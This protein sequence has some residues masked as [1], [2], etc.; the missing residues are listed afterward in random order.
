MPNEDKSPWRLK[1]K[2]GIL[3]NIS[4]YSDGIKE[5]DN[6]QDAVSSSV[7]YRFD[8]I[9]SQTR[10]LIDITTLYLVRDYK[11][12]TLGIDLSKTVYKHNIMLS[13]TLPRFKK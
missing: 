2:E 10:L 7:K 3:A 5:S 8:S 12:T 6:M 13:C 4:G 1:P 11:A 9:E